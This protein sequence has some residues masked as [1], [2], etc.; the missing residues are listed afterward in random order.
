MLHKQRLEFDGCQVPVVD[1][2]FPIEK[3]DTKG[4]HCFRGE[5]EIEERAEPRLVTDF[6]GASNGPPAT[7]LSTVG[8]GSIMSGD[9]GSACVKQEGGCK[10]GDEGMDDNAGDVQKCRTNRKDKRK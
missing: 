6:A 1:F 4:R 9:D 7:A 8:K 3:C 2:V 10:N 5:K